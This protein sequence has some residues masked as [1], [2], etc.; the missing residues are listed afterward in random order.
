MTARNSAVAASIT[1]IIALVWFFYSVIEADRA[2][3]K[4]GG[5]DILAA[6]LWNGRASIAFA[7]LV[8]VWFVAVTMVLV[9]AAKTR[10]LAP[11][12]RGLPYSSPVTWS[13]AIPIVGLMV[14]YV[15]LI[16]L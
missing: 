16:V 14:G 4:G 8:G 11:L 15:A 5:G 10:S 3:P 1:E 9:H 2:V 6:H 13:L 12:I 7:V